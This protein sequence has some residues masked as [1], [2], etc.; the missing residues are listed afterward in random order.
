MFM[1]DFQRASRRFIAQTQ[2]HSTALWALLLAACGGGGGGGGGG[3]PALTSPPT[4][5]PDPSANTTT[6]PPPLAR[7]G[8]PA[9]DPSTGNLAE[10][11]V[12]THPPEP[13]RFDIL[14]LI[15]LPQRVPDTGDEWIK[16]ADIRA[17][18]ADGAVIRGEL[19][20]YGWSFSVSDDR[21]RADDTG[22]YARA[23]RDYSG[24]VSDDLQLRVTLSKGS[25]GLVSRTVEIEV[26]AKVES[27]D[28]H[29]YENHPFH[30]PIGYLTKAAGW[31]LADSEG[32]NGLFHVDAT[33]RVWFIGT[34]GT[35]HLDYERPADSDGNNLYH[36]RL[37]RLVDGREEAMN[38]SVRVHDIVNERNWA[39]RDD[40]SGL[41]G[42]SRE[43]DL[44]REVPDDLEHI[45]HGS[46]WL[47]PSAGP[48]VLTWSFRTIF[49]PD[50]IKADTRP[51][52]AELIQYDGW[53]PPADRFTGDDRFL[54]STYK[55]EKLRIALNKVFETLQQHVNIRFIEVDESAGSIGHFRI[56]IFE[57]PGVG[58][59]EAQT[60]GQARFPKG[61]GLKYIRL[62]SGRAQDGMNHLIP[63]EIGH[64]LG[65][66]HPWH[67]TEHNW[68]TDGK[69]EHDSKGRKDTV[70]SYNTWDASGWQELELRLLKLIYGA[71]ADTTD[72]NLP[73]GHV[74]FAKRTPSSVKPETDLFDN[75]S[76]FKIEVKNPAKDS[77]HSTSGDRNVGANVTAKVFPDETGSKRLI[78]I[79]FNVFGEQVAE[80]RVFPQLRGFHAELF[81]LRST[82]DKTIFGLYIKD[83]DGIPFYVNDH[84]F[85]FSTKISLHFGPQFDPVDINLSLETASRPDGDFLI[86]GQPGVG[87]RL[88]VGF[89][90][91]EKGYRKEVRDDVWF[92]WRRDSDDT[93][94]SREAGYT[95][96]TPGIY[97]VKIGVP[98]PEWR[99]TFIIER[100]IEVRADHDP[101]Q[102]FDVVGFEDVR[103]PDPDN[104]PK[105]VHTG[106][107]A[108]EWFDIKRPVTLSGGGGNDVFA[109]TPI[110]GDGKIKIT[111]FTKGVDKIWLHSL[112]TGPA[113]AFRRVDTNKDGTVDAT[114]I[115]R[116]DKPERAPVNFNDLMILENF[117]EKLE[118]SDF[119]LDGGDLLL[120]QWFDVI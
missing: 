33:G 117:T 38:L 90:D 65:L 105:S 8:E 94:L 71:A 24:S 32:D 36:L 83:V 23:D 10:S 110:R 13:V 7:Q 64:L 12:S 56:W 39:Q 85:R 118:E 95:P 11:T 45:M 50:R 3:G 30:K 40:Y 91:D 2:S 9:G 96:D 60:V 98:A 61:S 72:G 66:K 119:L 81:E 26:V 59:F 106:T 88:H 41:L 51:S 53:T 108:A 69:S 28:L 89:Y 57:N 63:H 19:I 92:E 114:I 120:V 15:S 27:L 54:D 84:D 70:M 73:P 58:F 104:P 55:I 16:V 17:L 48:L 43:A 6:T 20:R 99:H 29:I 107:D 62:L 112:M 77:G 18:D 79:K 42:S 80:G 35:P 82:K 109:I 74:P 37:I 102:G 86:S 115:G 46:H 78:D 1:S 49:S 52:R 21:F 47:M 93:I 67:G 25:T 34:V 31:R 101:K 4:A 97:K 22:L 100:T 87:A 75:R 5:S 68:N 76:A 103:P 113:I 116:A 14:P 111:D 44:H